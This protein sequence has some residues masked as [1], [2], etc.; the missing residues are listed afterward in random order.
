MSKQSCPTCGELIDGR[1]LRMHQG[2]KTCLDMAEKKKRRPAGHKQEKAK[3]ECVFRLLDENKPQD[4]YYIDGGG[5]SEV[6]K[7]CGELK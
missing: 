6:C 2:T 3:C 1:G 7:K 5:F 4:K